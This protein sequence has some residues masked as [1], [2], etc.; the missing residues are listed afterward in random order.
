MKKYAILT[1]VLVLAACGGGTGSNMDSRTAAILSNKR[2]TEMNSFII[3][4]GSRPTINPNAHIATT[5]E[6]GGVRYDLSDVKFKTASMLLNTGVDDNAIIQFETTDGKID[7]IKMVLAGTSDEGEDINMNIH[8][9]RRGDSNVFA[10]GILSFVVDG[11]EQAD[12]HASSNFGLLYESNAKKHESGLRYCDFGVVQWGDVGNYDTS[13]YFAGGY[14][15]KRTDVNSEGNIDYTKMIELA[16][17]NADER[18]TFTGIADGVVRIGSMSDDSAVLY[19]AN[20]KLDLSTTATLEFHNG[21]STLVA[22]FDNWY[23]VTATMNST[24]DLVDLVFTNGAKEGFYHSNDYDFKWQRDGNHLDTHIAEATRNINLGDP[25]N[26]DH[27][28]TVV[29]DGFVQYY[30]DKGNPAEA[31]GVIRYGDSLHESG[32]MRFDMGFGLIKD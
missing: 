2:L 25:E 23:D 8:A 9:N 24:G 16:H 32:A 11:E 20:N 27:S 19:N 6:D 30:G 29:R 22:N 31:V 5:L 26:P 7:K 28:D 15:V 1:S 13:N 14:D 21:T 10:D 18:L 12:V 4:G 3:V 17:E